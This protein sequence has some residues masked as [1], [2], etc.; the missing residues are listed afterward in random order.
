LLP[1]NPRQVMNYIKTTWP[2]WDQLQGKKH[3][4]VLTDDHGACDEMGGM[5][6][7][8]E[9]RNSS[10]ITHFGYTVR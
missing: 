9:L 10:F 5:K 3:L 1:P 6:I 2:Y 8:E 4:W 7:V